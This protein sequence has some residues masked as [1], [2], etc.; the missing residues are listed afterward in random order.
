MFCQ[1]LHEHFQI[2]LLVLHLR[3]LCYILSIS[4]GLGR[5]RQGPPQ[6]FSFAARFENEKQPC[7]YRVVFNIESALLFVGFRTSQ[8]RH[9]GPP[10]YN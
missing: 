9:V 10:Q 6:Q 4:F 7:A 1:R 5:F 3:R 8:T 2:A